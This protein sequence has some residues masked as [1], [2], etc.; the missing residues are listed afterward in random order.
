MLLHYKYSDPGI[1]AGSE[2]FL[3]LQHEDTG[4]SISRTDDNIGFALANMRDGHTTSDHVLERQGT[5]AEQDLH[6]TNNITYKRTIEEPS[7]SR[8]LRFSRTGKKSVTLALSLSKPM[9]LPEKVQPRETAVANPVPQRGTRGP[10][11]AVSDGNF[12]KSIMDDTNSAYADPD[13]YSID[14]TTSHSFHPSTMKLADMPRPTTK[15]L[16]CVPFTPA[17]NPTTD[18]ARRHG[19]RE[20][21]SQPQVCNVDQHRLSEQQHEA[22]D[23][24]TETIAEN[25]EKGEFIACTKLTPINP[26]THTLGLYLS[27]RMKP[28]KTSQAFNNAPQQGGG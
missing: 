17:D 27:S 15:N 14:T 16:D 24:Q 4:G 19:Y 1:A 13:V 18:R 28:I 25:I 11:N 9:R 21:D 10:K 12:C 22:P 2:Q 3:D 6:H 23:L 5:H 7:T 20:N 26:V 8:K